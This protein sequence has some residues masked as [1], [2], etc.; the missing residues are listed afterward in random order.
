MKQRRAAA[1]EDL[2]PIKVPHPMTGNT[3]E[4]NPR[5]DARIG[6]DIGREL[7]RLPGLVAW[8]RQ[9]RDSAKAVLREARHHEH[10]VSEDL[11]SEYRNQTRKEKKTPTETEIR[12]R[13]R[14]DRRMRQAFRRRM[15]AEQLYDALASAV[16]NLIDKRWTL[17]SLVKWELAERGVD[18]SE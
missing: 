3:I 1:R 8:Y 2:G 4:V 18:D 14:S 10:N 15:D 13:I 16:D 6:D 9:L 5:M 17:A 12:M 7:R 11:D